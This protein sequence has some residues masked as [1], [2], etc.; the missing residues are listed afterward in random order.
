[1]TIDLDIF[2]GFNTAPAPA[3]AP[4][5]A[6]A[7]IYFVKPDQLTW[8]WGY[9]VR[10][11]VTA[12]RPIPEGK[13]ASAP[14]VFRTG[15]K[16][17]PEYFTRSKFTKAWQ[18]FTIDL[19]SMSVHGV[20]FA[21]LTGVARDIMIKKWGVM[22]DSG[23]FICNRDGVDIRNNY[24]TG[25]TD[26]GHDPMIDPLACAGSRVLVLETVK[27]TSGRTAGLDMAR[28][29]AFDSNQAPPK[30]TKDLLDNDPRIMTASVIYPDGHL[31]GFPQ[32]DGFRH[33]YPLISSPGSERW[34]P[35]RDLEKVLV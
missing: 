19:L 14:A 4:D 33:P 34:F 3:P 13:L 23:R 21:D 15:E 32:F 17:D 28:L 25:K 27:S 18:F 35:L 6:P 11:V 30:V 7:S 26:R 9:R 24:I 29:Q 20:L 1:M 10:P 2:L 8:Y 22:Y 31:T 12:E 5:Q 16:Q